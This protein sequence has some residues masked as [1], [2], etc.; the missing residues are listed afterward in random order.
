MFHL[1]LGFK[2]KKEMIASIIIAIGGGVCLALGGAALW[3]GFFFS[4]AGWLAFGIFLGVF[5]C[6]KPKL[7]K[8]RKRRRNDNL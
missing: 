4:A 2:E 8:K 1:L 5:A 7:S 6:L 3:F